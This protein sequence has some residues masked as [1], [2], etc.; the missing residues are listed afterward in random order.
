MRG[1][2]LL[3]ANP[4]MAKTDIEGRFEI[5]NLPAGEHT[6]RLWHEKA[7]YL[8]EIRVGQHVT[9]KRG[10]LTIT[11]DEN[12]SEFPEIRVNP[13]LFDAD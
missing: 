13:S 9:D 1:Y 12:I 3:R 5:K 10:R 2:V 8:R 4:Y 6:F 11:V 7:G